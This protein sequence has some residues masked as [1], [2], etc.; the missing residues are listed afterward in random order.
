MLWLDQKTEI[1]NA[2]F[3]KLF[4]HGRKALL[5]PSHPNHDM[6]TGHERCTIVLAEISQW[7]RWQ[8]EL[9]EA[10]VRSV[11]RNPKKEFVAGPGPDSCVILTAPL[12]GEGTSWSCRATFCSTRR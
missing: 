1:T 12:D 2:S 6:I 4:A 3:A 9:L 8:F 10:V 7:S 5:H 11:S